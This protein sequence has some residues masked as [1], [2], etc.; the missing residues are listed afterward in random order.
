M[1]PSSARYA[2]VRFAT[3]TLHLSVI[4][5]ITLAVS[6]FVHHSQFFTLGHCPTVEFAKRYFLADLPL[7]IGEHL[8]WFIER[9]IL[10]VNLI[11]LLFYVI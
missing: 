3:I 2:F 10:L 5:L 11:I 4:I 7:K 9:I 1:Y 8:I 6:T